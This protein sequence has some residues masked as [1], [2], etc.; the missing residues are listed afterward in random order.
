MLLLTLK[1]WLYFSIKIPVIFFVRPRIINMNDDFGELLIKFK[2]RT[3]NHLNS[4]YFGVLAVGADLA[5]GLLAMHHIK[6]S[7][8]NI[9]IIFKDIK[10]DFLQRVEADAHFTCRDGQSIKEMI[11]EAVSTGERV[12]R[13]IKI[14]VTAPSQSGDEVLAVFILTLSLKLK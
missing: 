7:G 4:M 12:N 2:R 3:K 8:K 1:Y 6:N 10:G 14:D 13:E 11:N 5:G 9:S